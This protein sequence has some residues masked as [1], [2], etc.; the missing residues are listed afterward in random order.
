[1]AVIPVG[2]LLL[3]LTVNQA[4]AWG[5]W[6]GDGGTGG[7][8]CGPAE[9]GFHH[10]GDLGEGYHHWNQD[11][12]CEGHWGIGNLL[13]SLGSYQQSGP[14]D[15]GYNAGIADAIYDH[16][17][18]LVYNPVG[19]CLPCHSEIYWNGFH[20]GYDKQWN[21][22]T[23]QSVSQGTS[24]NIYGNHNFVNVAQDSGQNSGP[25]GTPSPLQEQNS[26]NYDGCGSG[27]GG[28]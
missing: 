26:C 27:D 23:E 11:G 6:N 10:W 1:M 24:I 7:G 15:N 21:T 12:C 3:G 9:E 18:N 17:N 28:P 5:P 2:L 14:Y 4:F 16:T 13:Q 8:C 20:H 22:Y 25:S 19:Q